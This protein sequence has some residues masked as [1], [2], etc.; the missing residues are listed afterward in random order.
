MQY[1]VKVS[2][3]RSGSGY[4]H[5]EPFENGE[6]K[7]AF[8]AEE[9]WRGMDE[10]FKPEENE[11]LEIDIAFYDDDADPMFDDPIST[12]SWDLTLADWEEAFGD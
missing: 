7:E 8:T 12:N 4:S 9:W 11:W 6:C 3:Y 2:Y 1:S 5:T 10:P